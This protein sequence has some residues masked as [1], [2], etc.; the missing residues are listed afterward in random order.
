MEKSNRK[1]T[2]R[3]IPESET[4]EFKRFASIGIMNKVNL[5]EAELAEVQA[6]I[7][8]ALNDI[9]EATESLEIGNGYISA[10][11]AFGSREFLNENY[12]IRAAGAKF[13][14]WG[15]SQD[16]ASY[17]MF[18]AEGAGELRFDKDE[19][20]PL[21]DIGFWSITVHDKDGL[22]HK[23]EFD[24][25]VLTMDQMKFNEDGSL[26]LKISAKPE[27]GNWLY[28]TGDKMVVWIRAYQADP[29][30]IGTYVPPAFIERK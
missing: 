15:N 7:D 25:Y 1:M 5:S 17:F 29:E 14:L 24:S 9:E 2:L 11:G 18:K 28:T 3:E 23:N 6:G 27:E 13:G 16:Q 21:L 10:T 20:P 26:V 22:V 4:E 19:L 8:S 12:L 30:K